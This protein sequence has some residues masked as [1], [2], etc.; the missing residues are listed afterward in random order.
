M[1]VRLCAEANSAMGTV[2][3]TGSCTSRSDCVSKASPTTVDTKLLV[4]LKVMSTR[5]GSPHSATM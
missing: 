2:T 3:D 1:I 4:T 5:V